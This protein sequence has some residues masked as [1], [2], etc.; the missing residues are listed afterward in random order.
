MVFDRIGLLITFAMIGR[1]GCYKFVA[2]PTTLLVPRALV[3]FLAPSPTVIKD[4]RL[5]IS[6]NF[7]GKHVFQPF[8]QNTSDIGTPLKGGRSSDKLI[9]TMVD[10][11]EHQS[12]LS[13]PG[14]WP[15]LQPA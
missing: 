12:L 5:S 13:K 2:P 3:D 9:H 7:L 6:S 8:T 1:F 4:C 14:H 10:V 11:I 15:D